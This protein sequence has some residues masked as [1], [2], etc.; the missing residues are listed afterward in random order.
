MRILVVEDDRALAT[1]VHRGLTRE[2]FHVDVEYDGESGLW[3]ATEQDYDLVIL[4]LMLPKLSGFRVVRELRERGRWM[5]VLMLTAKDGE[6]DEAEAFEA[7][8]DD[9]VTKPFSFVSLVPRIRALV[10]RAPAER[11]VALTAGDLV[12]DPVAHTVHRGDAPIELTA[13]EFQLLEFL[14]RHPDEALSKTLILDGVWDQALD[15][16]V[17]LVEV[18]AGYLRRKVDAPFGAR[19]IETVRGVG[20]R[21]RGD[22]GRPA[23]D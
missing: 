8:A 17:N 12:L 18:Y 1:V 9:Y 20:Y 16:D 23:A 11:P 6:Y 22:G 2:G 15:A 21:F 19:S 5:P 3:A 10:R 14:M 4:D 13:R 7:G